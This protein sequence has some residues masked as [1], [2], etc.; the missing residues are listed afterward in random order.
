MVRKTLLTIREFILEVM[1]AG[2]ATSWFLTAILAILAVA[3][4]VATGGLSLILMLAIPGTIFLAAGIHYVL[5]KVFPDSP[6]LKKIG[7]ILKIITQGLGAGGAT[8]W[9]LSMVLPAP[10]MAAMGSFFAGFMSAAAAATLVAAMPYVIAGVVAIAAIAYLGVRLYRELTR[11]TNDTNRLHFAASF[12]LTVLGAGGASFW[13]M[14]TGFLVAAAFGATV[15]APVSFAVCAAVAVSVAAIAMG[16]YL[17]N[18]VGKGK[19]NRLLKEK[20]SRQK[21]LV[22]V[23]TGDPTEKQKSYV[24]Y[25][26]IIAELGRGS[27]DMKRQYNKPKCIASDAIPLRD[28]FFRMVDD[29]LK[30]AN[31]SEKRLNILAQKVHTLCEAHQSTTNP[32]NKIALSA[33]ITDV[34]QDCETDHSGNCS[35]RFFKKPATESRLARECREL[36]ETYAPQRLVA[37]TGTS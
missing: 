29:Y 16:H 9:L 12:V 27:D 14:T 33:T 30:K 36:L 23:T 17:Y 1:G 37:S 11:G 24:I 20:M 35:L 19:H 13:L 28:A 4:A 10:A 7:Y 31:V 34:M 5:R 15:A 18:N 22:S 6:V 32:L 3:G 25:T 2:G 26:N 8:A 21:A